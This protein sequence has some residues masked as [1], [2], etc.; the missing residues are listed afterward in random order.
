MG[1]F[2]NQT[3]FCPSCGGSGFSDI[4]DNKARAKCSECQGNGVFV[5]TSDSLNFFSSSSYFDF[6]KREKIKTLR[7]VYVVIGLILVAGFILG[8]MYL[9]SIGGAMVGGN[10][11]KP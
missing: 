6:L 2:F 1:S 8:L 7:I 3:I 4:E 9:M 10:I 5:R 11:V